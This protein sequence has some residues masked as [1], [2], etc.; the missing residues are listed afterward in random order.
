MGRGP[1][2]LRWTAA[3]QFDRIT[4]GIGQFDGGLTARQLV[5]LFQFRF[6]RP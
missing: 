1:T 5:D 4:V 3:D 6:A 2:G